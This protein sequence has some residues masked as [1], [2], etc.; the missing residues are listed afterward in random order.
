[1]PPRGIGGAVQLR[2][3][4]LAQE[5]GA[6]EE[7]GNERLRLQANA[8]LPEAALDVPP[9]DKQARGGQS[10]PVKGLVQGAHL[11]AVRQR[12]RVGQ[13]TRIPD[14]RAGASAAGAG[15]GL[16][17]CRRSRPLHYEDHFVVATGDL[18]A[19][20]A[21]H[22]GRGGVGRET[23]ALERAAGGQAVVGAPVPIDVRLG[24]LSP[25]SG[26]LQ[27]G[28]R[29]ERRVGRGVGRRSRIPDIIPVNQ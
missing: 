11:G 23:A 6:A 20:R 19:V 9:V 1:M 18:V 24:N 17:P 25:Q 15:R 2:V 7:P 13:G 12:R 10:W 5:A 28:L 16:Q 8:E 14:D 4:H 3:G 22:V 21:Q 29:D 27:Q 26:P